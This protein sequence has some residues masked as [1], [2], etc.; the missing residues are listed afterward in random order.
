MNVLLYI[1]ILTCYESIPYIYKELEESIT[2]LK[3]LF[4]LF[5]KVFPQIVIFWF[6]MLFYDNFANITYPFVKPLLP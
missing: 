2:P 4:L 5:L 3:Y 1:K 6:I